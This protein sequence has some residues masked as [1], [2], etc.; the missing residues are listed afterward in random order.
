VPYAPRFVARTDTAVTD[1]IATL[2]AKPIVAHAGIA[3][4]GAAE[5]YLADG[6]RGTNALFLDALG[7]LAWREFTL[8]VSGTNLLGLRYFDAQYTYIGAQHVL[9]AT[10]TM[11][12]LTLEIHIEGRGSESADPSMD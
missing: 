7:S 8:G 12:M 2:A 6:S 9:V 11:V 1:R 4:E 10:P 5:R 3:L